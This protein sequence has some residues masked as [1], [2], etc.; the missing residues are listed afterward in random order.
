MNDFQRNLCDRMIEIALEYINAGVG[1][2]SL[3]LD[4]SKSPAIESVKPF[5]LRLPTHTEIIRWFSRPRGMGVLC[6]VVSRGLEVLDFDCWW[7]FPDWYRAVESIAVRLPIV[8][9][10]SGGCHVYYRC[11]R[12]C[13]S[14]KIAMDSRLPKPTLIETRGEGGY[15]VGCSSPAAVHPLNYPYVQTMGPGLPEIPWITPEERTA[16][17]QAARPFDQDGLLEKARNK[18]RSNGAQ[19]GPG[20]FRRQSHDSASDLGRW[21][22]VLTEDGWRSADSVYW[23]RLGK[24]HGVSAALRLGRTGSLVLVV[25]STNANVPDETHNL[26]SYVAYSRF[27]GNMVAAQ[28]FLKGLQ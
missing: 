3:K 10:P 13:K 17:W 2:I 15:V 21:Q 11:K 19:R 9:T 5:H 27:N 25:F 12:I 24:S 6:G 26:R 7:P 8:E 28:K 18:H 22:Q 1:V 20:Q 23:T 4:G 16:L 14:K